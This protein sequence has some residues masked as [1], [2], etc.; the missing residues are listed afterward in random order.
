MTY[1]Q[2]NKTTGEK[3]VGINPYK[4]IVTIQ[5]DSGKL[6]K[7]NMTGLNKIFFL[8]ME[9]LRLRRLMLQTRKRRNR[10]MSFASKPPISLCS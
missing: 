3:T 6:F 2:T 9:P 4:R 10:R 5:L 8:N 1:Y 7:T